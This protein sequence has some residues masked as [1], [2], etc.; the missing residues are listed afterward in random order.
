MKKIIILLVLLCTLSACS[1]TK[2]L[3]NQTST[4]SSLS[5]LRDGLSYETA[6]IINKRTD[7][8]GI[9]AEYEWLRQHYPNYK[10]NGQMLTKSKNIP[11]DI[12]D[13]ITSSGLKKT[14]YFDISKFSGKF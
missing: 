7:K 12:I 10:F 2:K 14:I 6:I 11:Y 9:D 1:S 3:S 4:E 8:Q 5:E 13:I